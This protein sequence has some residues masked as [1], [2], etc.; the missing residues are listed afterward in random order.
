MIRSVSPPPEAKYYTFDSIM[1]HLRLPSGAFWQPVN[2]NY[3]PGPPPPPRQPKSPRQANTAQGPQPPN[4]RT[5]N[6]S[7]VQTQVSAAQRV[8]NA[9]PMPVPQVTLAP[10]N[11]LNYTRG[12]GNS[13]GNP[14]QRHHFQFQPSQRLPRHD[15]HQSRYFGTADH[16]ETRPIQPGHRDGTEEEMK[17]SSSVATQT[18]GESS[19]ETNNS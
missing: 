17:Y 1:G 3:D 11:V 13:R 14:S 2:P 19:R 15:G 10:R 5:T 9:L 4:D 16:P 7:N 6:T 8:N 18:R 12:R